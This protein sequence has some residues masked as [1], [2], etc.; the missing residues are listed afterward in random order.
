MPLRTRGADAC[1]FA[2]TFFHS[3][4]SFSVTMAASGV[5]GDGLHKGVG[6]EAHTRVAIRRQNSSV[7]QR[8]RAFVMTAR[9]LAQLLKARPQ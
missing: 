2:L 5:S 7:A 1:I 3:N 6:A 4:V 9:Q 8:S